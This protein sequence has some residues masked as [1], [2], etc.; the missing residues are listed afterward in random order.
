MHEEKIINDAKSEMDEMKQIKIKVKINTP[1]KTK[2]FQKMH[3]LS[4]DSVDTTH[5]MELVRE[6]D[7]K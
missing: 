2:I 5:D 3:N 6:R 1:S 7:I 4:V